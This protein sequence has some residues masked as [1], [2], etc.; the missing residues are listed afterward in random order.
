MV[1]VVGQVVVVGL[2]LVVVVAVAASAGLLVVAVVVLVRPGLLSLLFAVFV[3]RV[4]VLVD[5]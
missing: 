1:V 2:G 4:V 5:C 3:L